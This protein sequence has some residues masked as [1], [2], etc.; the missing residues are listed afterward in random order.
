MNSSLD[1]LVTNLSDNDFKYFFEKFSG[2]FLE[3][4]KQKGAYPYEYMDSFVKL[5]EDKLPDRSKF[6]SSLKDECISEKGYLKAVDVWNVF[7]I[8]T[9]GDYHDLYLK[10]DVLLSADVFEK[11]ISTCLGHYGLDPCN[12]F[13]SPGLSWVS[14][15]KMTG[16]KLDLVSDIDMHLFI[17]KVMRGGTSYIAKRPSKAKTNTY[18]VMVV[19]KKLISLCIWMQI[20]YMDGQ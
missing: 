4:V 10:T 12:Y 3:L 15:L 18:G 6:F 19:M 2:G 5:S 13:S 16:I 17:E 8:N 9:M 20:I 11:F 1:S 7:Q 14:M